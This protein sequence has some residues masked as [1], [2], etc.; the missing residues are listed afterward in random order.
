MTPSHAHVRSKLTGEMLTNPT[1][2]SKTL[3]ICVCL[4]LLTV[5]H[6]I[7]DPIHLRYRNKLRHEQL[8]R[9]Q[10][11]F[12]EDLNPS[13]A[14]GSPP[15]AKKPSP[16]KPAHLPPLHAP[17]TKTHPTPP[18]APAPSPTPT[19]ALA[20]APAPAPAP[21]Q[22]QRQRPRE[23]VLLPSRQPPDRNRN[24]AATAAAPKHPLPRLGYSR[25]NSAC[26]GRGCK[27]QGLTATEMRDA[28]SRMRPVALKPPPLVLFGRDIEAQL[29]K[30]DKKAVQWGH[31]EVFEYEGE[32]D[33]DD[34]EKR[35]EGRDG[36]KRGGG[37][38]QDG[39]VG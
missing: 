6:F 1:P 33:D 4:C 36:D 15:S 28:W 32:S 9:Q 34:D 23:H 7:D 17:Q 22:H 30:G 21:A 39:R 12:V 35:N 25:T 13:D 20:P 26:H 11:G 29:D 18:V 31:V 10:T 37:G 14:G 19:S 5:A 24:T 3:C 2:F 16:P 27:I 38:T 8:R